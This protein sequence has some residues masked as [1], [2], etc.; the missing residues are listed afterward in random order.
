MKASDMLI[1]FQYCIK[2]ESVTL[3]GFSWE[4]VIVMAIE[5]KN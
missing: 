2:I 5:S 4:Q 3:N 1:S